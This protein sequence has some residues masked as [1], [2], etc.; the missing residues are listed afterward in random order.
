MRER[1][2][3]THLA[4]QLI[5][6]GNVVSGSERLET[7]QLSTSGYESN[8]ESAVVASKSVQ[9]RYYY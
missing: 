9:V 6:L 5:T 3:N 1:H 7:T 8:F 2:V 4:T